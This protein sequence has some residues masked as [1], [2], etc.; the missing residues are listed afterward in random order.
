MP[1]TPLIHPDMKILLAVALCA[2]PAI[3]QQSPPGHHTVPY[4]LHSGVHD[5]PERGEFLAYE[6]TVVVPNAAWSQLAFVGAEL[7]ERS[8]LVLT[9]SRNGDVQ[10]LDA[11]SLAQWNQSSGVFVG[12]RVHVE[13]YAGA[14]DAGVFV[15]LGHVLVGD[16]AAPLEAEGYK[17]LCGADDRVASTDN[18]IGRLLLGGCT[19]W[20]VTNGAFLSAG[21]CIDFDPDDGGAMLPDGIPDLTGA[22]EFNVPASLSN[23]T[24]VPAPLNDQYPIDMS[25]FVFRFDG[26]GQGGGK[27]W[28]VF[29][30]FP[31]S[32]TGLLPHEAYGLPFRVSFEDPAVG[33]TIRITGFGS[34][35]TPPGSAGGANAQHFTNQTDSGTYAG[36]L[37]FGSGDISHTYVVDTTPGGSGSPVIRVSSNVA[38]GIHTNGGCSSGSNSGTSFGNP[39]LANALHAFKGSSTIHVDVGHP[40]ASDFAGGSV[41]SPLRKFGVGV[42]DVPTGGL[43]SVVAGS[44]SLAPGETVVIDR[45]MT[46]EAPVGS[47]VI[48]Q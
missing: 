22:V 1:S 24:T 38:I 25:S 47:A 35:V 6:A 33:N 26:N 40:Y 46:V 8:R 2:L 30:V 14:G 20:R 39:D 28:G 31:N 18:R 44:Y 29:R 45:A 21:H 41:F 37:D 34:D 9:S 32:N 15:E 36:E 23:G 17:S 42:A 19:A 10:H 48:G 16:L 4:P 11:E 7:G 12:G 5:G 3:A 13:L 27:D 43:V